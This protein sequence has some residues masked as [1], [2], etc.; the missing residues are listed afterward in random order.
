MSGIGPRD[1]LQ[2]IGI[3][4]KYHLP[5]VGE[6]LQDHIITSFWIHSKNDQERFG[7]S[8]FD[9]VN[10]LHHLKYHVFG[11]G[12]LTSNGIEAGAFFQSGINNDSWMRPD[13]Q[14]HTFAVKP[15]ID[16]GLKFKHALNYDEKHYEG[17]Y[18]EVFKG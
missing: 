8:P 13:L 9:T 4:L 10:P 2:S 5:G 6:N 12:P 3:P 17:A 16:F 15:S 11:K 14:L 7:A 1:H 18:D